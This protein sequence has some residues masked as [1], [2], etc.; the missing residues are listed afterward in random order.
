LLQGWTSVITGTVIPNGVDAGRSAAA[1]PSKRWAHLGRFVLAVGGVSPRKGSI[2]LREAMALLLRERP[3]GAARRR[4]R[5]TLFDD[6]DHRQHYDACALALGIEPPV[7]GAVPDDD[8]PS[9]VASASAFAPPRPR[10]GSGSQPS[11]PWPHAAR[12]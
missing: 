7:L 6:W 8:L 4:R 5:V 2:D 9:L 1:R 3:G 12:W 11:M 10:R